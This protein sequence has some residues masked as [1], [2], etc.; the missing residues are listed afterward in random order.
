MG[1]ML[2]GPGPG[3]SGGLCKCPGAVA[4]AGEPEVDEPA[5]VE[6]G[7][8]V[9]EPDVVLGDAAV[10]GGDEP[11][12][13]RLDRRPPPAV[14]VLP[15]G[16]GG[17]PAGGGQQGVLGVDGQNAPGLGGGAA[18]A[19]RAAAAARFELGCPVAISL[20]RPRATVC[21]AGQVTVPAWSS[22]V[23]SSRVKPP[24]TAGRSSGG[25]ITAGWPAARRCS[26][27]SPVP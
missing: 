11:G 23:K 17:G 10:A 2:G 14:F 24:G 20:G 9:V 22:M 18:L 13:G 6:G 7:G 25:L 16:V 5:E 27:S 8:P 15:G 4:G 26:R 3:G 21:P 1:V 19:Q 12:D